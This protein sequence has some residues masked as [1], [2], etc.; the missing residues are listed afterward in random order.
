MQAKH[1]ADLQEEIEKLVN[2]SHVH[3]PFFLG[4]SMSYVD[5]QLAPWIIRLSRVL[6]PYRGWTE[7]AIGSRLGR[8][9]QAIEEN[10]HVVATTSSDELYLESYQRYTGELSLSSKTMALLNELT[11]IENRPESGGCQL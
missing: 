11:S 6:K 7:P 2:A 8:W 10:E 9:I 1:A 5:I 3:G 4:P